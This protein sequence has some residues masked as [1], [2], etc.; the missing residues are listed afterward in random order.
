MGNEQPNC[1]F[2]RCL[3]KKMIGLMM[4]SLFVASS[5]MAAE[6]YVQSV[7]AKVL[8]APSFKAAVLAEVTK[9]YKFTVLGRQGSWVKVQLSAGEGYVPALLVSARPPLSSSGLIKAEDGEIKGSVRRRA[10]TFTSAAAAR[11]LA[12]DDR[13][14]LSMEEKVNYDALAEIES[15]KISDDELSRF[16]AETR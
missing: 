4:L 9:G 14:R 13:R 8:N 2:A 3:M 15:V 10:S 12:A 7:K 5:V 6:V 16:I 1:Q 11:G